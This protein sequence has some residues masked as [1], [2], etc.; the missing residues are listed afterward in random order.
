VA[1]ERW[2][3]SK[4]EGR[5]QKGEIGRWC[6]M[7]SSDVPAAQEFDGSH[8]RRSRSSTPS[9]RRRRSVVR[10]SE[11]FRREAQVGVRVVCAPNASSACRY[12]GGTC[13]QQR[14]II[15]LFPRPSRRFVTNGGAQ[16]RRYGRISE[17]KANSRA[18]VHAT[19]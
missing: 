18:V 6:T 4:K 12:S 19:I 7:F 17:R 3:R 2:R 13:R 1:C 15:R 16:R 8:V 11:A 14:V 5:W 10:E 9:L